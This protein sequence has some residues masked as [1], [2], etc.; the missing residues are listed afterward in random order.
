MLAAPL[1]ENH[2]AI[3]KCFH[4]AQKFSTPYLD[5][6][7]VGTSGLGNIAETVVEGGK[8][9]KGQELSLEG[10][11]AIYTRFKPLRPVSVARLQALTHPAGGPMPTP[12]NFTA[13]N[14]QP[15]SA[16]STTDDEPT[17][18]DT[19]PI[20]NQPT[21]SL[22]LDP[23]ELFSQLVV[24]VD[25]VRLGKR[26]SYELMSARQGETRFTP[27]WLGF[28]RVGGGVVRVWREWLLKM[29]KM[30]KGKGGESGMGSWEAGEADGG[31]ILW[32]DAKQNVGIRMGVE[33]HRD[34]TGIQATNADQALVTHGADDEEPV[35][36]TLFYE[37]ML[38][39]LSYSGLL[40]TMYA[41]TQSQSFLSDPPSCCS[42]T[43]ILSNRTMNLPGKLEL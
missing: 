16:S 29:E 26:P 25:L 22:S 4:P 13:P 19:Q 12:P 11:K 9:E 38:P 21:Q 8:A 35:S 14:T 36:C 10:L 34:D 27:I 15:P 20:P 5:C 3:L 1:A 23:H 28:G 7:Y 24:G 6:Q 43:N 40:M 18:S 31:G 41:L 39:R 32:A 33:V 37:G 2:K 42:S 17:D 30:G